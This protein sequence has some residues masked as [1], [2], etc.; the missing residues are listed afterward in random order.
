MISLSRVTFL[1]T[2]IIIGGSTLPAQAQ[3][4]ALF[5]GTKTPYPAPPQQYTPAPA[6]YKP[7]FVNHVGRHGSRFFTKAGSDVQVLQVLEEAQK[8]KALTSLGKQL[9]IMTQRF[10]GLQKGNYENITGLGVAEQQLI[11]KRLL[12]NYKQ[13]FTGKG[14]EIY[15]THKI[16]TQQSAT[17]FL[18][19]FAAYTG[20]KEYKI[21][22]DSQDTM[23]RFYDLSPAYQAFKKSAAVQQAVDSLRNDH[24]TGQYAQQICSRLF[25]PAFKT[26]AVTFSQNLYDVYCGSFSIPVEIKKHGYTPNSLDFRIAFTPQQL[27]WFAFINGAE[28]FLEKGAGRDTAG[29]Q[30]TVATPLLAN[31][32]NTTSEVVDHIKQKDAILRFTHAEA[33]SPFATL[34][35]IPQ[36]SVPAV[37]IYQYNKHWS[38]EAIIPLSANIQWIIYS[39]GA[40]HLVKVLLNEKEMVLPVP[41]Q[42]AP[43]YKWE[44]VKKYY[45]NK[46]RS[47]ETKKTVGSGEAVVSNRQ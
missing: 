36:A 10:V 33:I 20:K 24:K 17:A 44:D 13:A 15:A 37:S 7:V 31:F 2:G 38:P 11:G 35:G 3:T 14:L 30:A 26:D 43:Y 6:G 9:L 4:N 28:D 8:N 29:I 12:G 47:L 42:Q 45:L 25:T 21:L 18:D 22:P 32:I 27:Q 39:N 34:L 1:I 46:L 5:T 41:T 40:D 23:L 16:R 19:S